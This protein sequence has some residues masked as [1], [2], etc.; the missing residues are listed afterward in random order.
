MPSVNSFPSM[1]RMHG[2]T[3]IPYCSTIYCGRSQVES[4]TMPSFICVSR[5]RCSGFVIGCWLP[6]LRVFLLLYG[7]DELIMRLTAVLQL[8]L[9]AGIG[10]PH[11]VHDVVGIVLGRVLAVD[12]RHQL[13]APRVG[14]FEQVQQRLLHR[15]R[16]G[17]QLAVEQGDHLA[18]LDVHPVDL[19][20]TRRDRDLPR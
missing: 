8:D 4:V 18:L 3:S 10:V 14:L 17:H 13:V 1:M 6:A 19:H 5:T 15:G 2:T 12:Q 20:R 16:G 11:G 9:E 7:N